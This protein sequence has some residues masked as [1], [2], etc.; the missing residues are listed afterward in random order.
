[1]EVLTERV[2]R[3]GTDLRSVALVGPRG[4]RPGDLEDLAWVLEEADRNH[5][6]AGRVS[7]TAAGVLR[8][9]GD[10]EQRAQDA[11][12][13]VL[14]IPSKARMRHLTAAVQAVDDLAVHPVVVAL[15]S[16]PGRRGRGSAAARTSSG[17][18]GASSFVH[19]APAVGRT[20][21]VAGAYA[22]GYTDRYRD[23]GTDP[24]TGG[25]LLDPPARDTLSGG[26]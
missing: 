10:T 6:D 3:A 7:W 4:T 14:V 18:G 23:P 5:A 16:R 11:D 19:G 25:P 1:V 9:E 8:G 17:A 15:P 2:R 24:V 13:L 12:A 20:L 26:R 22:G 21:P